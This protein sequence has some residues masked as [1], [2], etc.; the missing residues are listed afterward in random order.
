MLDLTNCIDQLC[1]IAK[2]IGDEKLISTALFLRQRIY[3]PESFVVFLGETCCGKSTIINSLLHQQILPVSSIPSTGAITEIFLDLEAD[4]QFYAAIN[5]NAKMHK[6]NIEQFRSMALKPD[7]NLSRLRITLPTTD[8][9]T[10]GTHLFDTPGY[11]SMVAEHE[12]VLISF[13]PECDFVVYMV[14]FRTGYQ[15]SDDEF[16]SLLKNLTRDEIPIYLVISRAPLDADVENKRIKEIKRNV[17]AQLSVP[18]LPLFIIPSTKLENGLVSTPELNLLWDSIQRELKSESR[19]MELHNV[20]I[21]YLHDLVNLLYAAVEKYLSYSKISEEEIQY[22]QIQVEEMGNKFQSAIDEILRPGFSKIRDQLIKV[23][24]LCKENMEKTILEEIDNQ[25]IFKKDETI[26]FTTSHLLPFQAQKKAE[27]IQHYLS[28]EFKA[29][30]RKL[31]DYLNGE[32]AK[33]EEDIQLHFSAVIDAGFNVAKGIAGKFLN[34]GLMQYFLQYGGQGGAGAGIANA[35]SHAL[36]KVG[37]IFNHTFSL[38][39]HNALK[40]F[41]AKIGLTSTK[42]LSAAVAGIIELLSM[43]LNTATWKPALKSKVKSGLEKWDEEA[44]SVMLSELDKLEQDNIRNI[45]MAKEYYI[46]QLTFDSNTSED[47]DLDLLHNLIDELTNIDK[48]L[49]AGE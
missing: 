3:H 6:L 45:N 18:D 40:Q 42:A 44:R 46:Q 7:A 5:K 34:N 12:D 28:V 11:D 19:L 1:D 24:H 22:I 29:L 27:D 9:A 47:A 17:T 10:S 36:K 20:F 4:S 35:A 32:I 43:T 48:E 2:Q 25:S 49:D 33:F 37:D 15:R 8:P 30:D 38:T 23:I 21:S 39:T 31:N 14:N 16:L 41:M 13:L 26:E